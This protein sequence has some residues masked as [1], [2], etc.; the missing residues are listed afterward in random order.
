V[1]GLTFY[2]ILADLTKMKEHH[3]QLKTNL[4]KLE[5]TYET[6]KYDERFQGIK[7]QVNA[8]LADYD[9]IMT[10]YDEMNKAAEEEADKPVDYAIA[11]SQV[12][13]TGLQATCNHPTDSWIRVVNVPMEL[14]QY[15][16]SDTDFL[17][18]MCGLLVPPFSP[19]IV[20]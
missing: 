20:R 9:A 11:C 14:R 6:L 19:F 12:I 8:S 3:E 16:Q 2:G 13:D 5:R 7:A 1:K 15:E 4:I 17:C 18:G 10:K